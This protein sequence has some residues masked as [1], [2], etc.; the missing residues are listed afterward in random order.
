MNLNDHITD[1]ARYTLDV[2]TRIESVAKEKIA[3][4]QDI[5]SDAFAHANT[6]TGTEANQTL[7][8]INREAREG[9]SQL[10]REPA[11]ARLVLEDESGKHRILYVARTYQVALGER[12]QLAS[13]HA[14]M[15]RLA[16]IPVGEDTEVKGPG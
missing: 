4:T 6:F 13:Y 14:P 11:I 5:G 12:A 15:G 1:L 10:A 3:A 8:K 9:Y 16:A 7:D 2:F